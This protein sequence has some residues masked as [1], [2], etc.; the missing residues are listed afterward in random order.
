MGV[1]VTS[2]SERWAEGIS[3][4]L[5]VFGLVRFGEWIGRRRYSAYFFFNFFADVDPDLVAL[6]LGYGG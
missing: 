3:A 6:G 1:G 5:L 2:A 4:F